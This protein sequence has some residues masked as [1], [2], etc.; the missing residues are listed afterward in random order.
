MNAGNLLRRGQRQG[1]GSEV[2]WKFSDVLREKHALS[3]PQLG[4]RR[5]PCTI[6]SLY[7][8]YS[9]V[10]PA[11]FGYLLGQPLLHLKHP[12]LIG[13][14]LRDFSSFPGRLDFIFNFMQF[15]L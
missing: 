14:Y 13:Y 6:K 5:D 8:S 12:P 3:P 10:V 1:S 4:V 2:S 9:T 15:S 11:H 7:P